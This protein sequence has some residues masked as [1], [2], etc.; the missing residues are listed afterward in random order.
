MT[1][2]WLKAVPNLKISRL[3][4]GST[5]GTAVPVHGTVGTTAGSY[6]YRYLEVPVLLLYLYVTGTG[7]TTT[8]PMLPVS[9]YT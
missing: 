9:G 1:S 5:Y 7:T 2:L 3:N 6:G 8:V 4:L